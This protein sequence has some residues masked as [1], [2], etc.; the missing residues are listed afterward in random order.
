LSTVFWLVVQTETNVSE[1]HM[2]SSSGSKNKPS[3]KPPKEGGDFSLH[4]WRCVPPK[5]QFFIDL[6]CV[7]T[8]MT[9]LFMV[10]AMSRWLQTPTHTGSSLTDFLYPGDGGDTFLG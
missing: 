10:T 1:E 2:A 6:C 5:H 7:T 4:L 8:N 3:G 9:I